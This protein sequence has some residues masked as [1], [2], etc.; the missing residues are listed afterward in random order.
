MLDP[1]WGAALGAMTSTGVDY[2]ADFSV[3]SLRVLE[4]DQAALLGILN[5]AFDLGR[6][7][8]SVELEAELQAPK[9][10]CVAVQTKRTRCDNCL[11]A[12]L[13]VE[14]AEQPVRVLPD[15]FG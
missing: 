14:L 2:D 12:I 1:S 10:L 6:V 15:G 5:F 7:L 4:A 13:D 3:T 9:S 11:A 8:L